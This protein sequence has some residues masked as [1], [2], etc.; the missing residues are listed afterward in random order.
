MRRIR[1]S[2]GVIAPVAQREVLATTAVVEIAHDFREV[3]SN[4]LLSTHRSSSSSSL[5][6]SSLSLH[7]TS[8]FSTERF[9]QVLDVV[10][11]APNTTIGGYGYCDAADM[12]WTPIASF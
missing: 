6:L 3:Q 10:A 1:D 11:V 5:L 4:C 7:L 2:K 9:Q 8:F 12:T